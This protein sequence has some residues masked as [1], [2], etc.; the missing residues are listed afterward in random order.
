MREDAQI[1]ISKC[2]ICGRNKK[3][4]KKPRAPM[5]TLRCGSI[6]DRYATDLVG[7]LPKTKAGNKYLLVCKDLYS[8][9]TEIYAI[10]DATAETCANKILVE[11]ISGFGVPLSL[12]SDRGRNYESDTY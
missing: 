6:C 1:H 10:P 12:H 3:P 7:P 4:G 2:S 11:Y 9:W 8:K 5:G